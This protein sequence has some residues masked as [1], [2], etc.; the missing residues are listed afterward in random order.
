MYKIDSMYEAM[1]EAVI[2]GINTDRIPGGWLQPLG[3][4]GG[5]RS[6]G[7]RTTGLV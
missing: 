6:P 2:S 7:Q 4:W 3:G 5:S 1:A